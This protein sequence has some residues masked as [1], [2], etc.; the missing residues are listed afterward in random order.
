MR[1]FG[2]RRYVKKSKRD[3]MLSTSETTLL[4]SRQYLASLS[5]YF[6]MVCTKTYVVLQMKIKKKKMEKKKVKGRKKRETEKKKEK[7][8]EER[9]LHARMSGK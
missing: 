2:Q 4:S 3:G 5:I 8:L 9:F 7:N 6:G 1:Q